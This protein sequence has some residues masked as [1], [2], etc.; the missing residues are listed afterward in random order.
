MNEP[1]L[2]RRFRVASYHV[3]P[4]GVARPSAIMGFLE[5]AAGEHAT[6]R[7]LGVTQL[8]P[9]GLTWVISRY[10]L[11]IARAPR[12]R[13][14]IEV[15][16]WPSG[17]SAIFA[18][19]DFEVTAADGEPIAVATTSWAILDLE[20]RRPRP[21]A[22]V[23]PP[24]FLLERRALVDDFASLPALEASERDVTLPVMLRDLDM[25]LHVNH[26]VYVQWALETVPLDLLRAGSP[27][28]VEVGYH[29][30]ARLGDRIVASIAKDGTARTGSGAGERVFLHR[31][32]HAERGTELARL[33]TTW[34]A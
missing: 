26:I 17:R 23:L 3:G 2:R 6:S 19:R 1:I 34:R 20:T 24:D 32:T 10:H 22:S 15:T 28:D 13:E 29:A 31:I 30:E 25:N 5:E 27:L 8:H 16:T 18:L 4:R 7:G 14:E 33:R 11:R 21:V 9:R 12:F